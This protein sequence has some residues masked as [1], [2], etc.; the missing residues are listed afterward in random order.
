MTPAI[1]QAIAE[2]SALGPIV[3][4]LDGKLVSKCETPEQAEAVAK[5]INDAHANVGGAS[6]ANLA[7]VIQRELT[8][9]GFTFDSEG[10]KSPPGPTPSRLLRI[11]EALHEHDTAGERAE[12]IRHAGSAKLMRQRTCDHEPVEQEYMANRP[13]NQRCRKCGG[14]F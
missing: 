13:G 9:A 5:L 4:T 14:I 2:A 1:V 8:D 3:E 12:A 7:S 6:T 11:A 10:F